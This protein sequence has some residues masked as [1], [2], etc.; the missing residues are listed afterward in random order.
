ME[1]EKFSTQKP[2][3]QSTAPAIGNSMSPPTF[4]L[5]AE[6]ED[7]DQANGIKATTC[8]EFRSRSSPNMIGTSIGTGVS[9]VHDRHYGEYSDVREIGTNQYRFSFNSEH[10]VRAE[11]LPGTQIIRQSNS[12][13]QLQ[14]ELQ[15]P[16]DAAGGW[17]LST[18]ERDL[19]NVCTTVYFSTGP[20]TWPR[21]SMYS[22][23][24]VNSIECNLITPSGF[25]NSRF[26]FPHSL[27]ENLNRLH[28]TITSPC[29]PLKVSH[30]KTALSSGF[31]LSERSGGNGVLFEPLGG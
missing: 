21:N 15:L 1:R 16:R 8:S 6:T 17:R 24:F 13:G 23:L 4:K 9:A 5:T 10:D 18:L 12:D 27:C 14:V 19:E 28:A 29:Q 2:T 22:T 7:K 30:K 26:E 3:K 20:L 31:F 11:A 25:R